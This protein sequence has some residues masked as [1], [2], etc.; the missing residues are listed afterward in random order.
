MLALCKMA[1]GVGNIG[2]REVPRPVPSADE[3]L[4]RVQAAGICG[5]DLHIQNWD[6]K[7]AIVPPVV[8]GHEFSGVIE[9]VGPAVRGLRPGERVTG[10]PTY[11]SC[12]RCAYC[13][14]GSYNLCADRTVLGYSADGAFAEFL[15]IPSERVHP[16]PDNVGFHAGALSEP[17][18]CCVH[19][20]YEGAGVA[21]HELAVVI[22]PGAIGLLALQ[23]LRA[24]GA[25]TV[26]LGKS[27]DAERLSLAR[28][29][30]AD[31]AVDVDREDPRKAVLEAGGDGGA[32]LVVECSGARASAGLGLELLRKRG[33]YVQMG[34]F[35]KPIELDLDLIAYKELRMSG[36]IAQKWSA[37]RTALALMA[38]GKVRLEPL[39]T[40]VLPLREWQDGFR[41]FR[42]KS[43]LKVVLTP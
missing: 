13:R 43:G 26:V 28:A 3:V 22:G 16:L 25:R 19:G 31:R 11:G 10:E 41:R 1:A 42:E 38:A 23:L 6:T 17:L 40:D 15:R 30:G 29:L 18:A 21:A 4:I 2:L 14:A 24:A 9:E 12:G 35:G 27:A 36:S 39:V 7:I 32:D 34:L 20:L 5:S 8:M 33:R 37:W